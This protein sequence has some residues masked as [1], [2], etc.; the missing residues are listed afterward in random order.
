MDLSVLS[1]RL[2]QKSVLFFSFCIQERICYNFSFPF[3]PTENRGIEIKF[4]LCC[5]C[6]IACSFVKLKTGSQSLCKHTNFHIHMHTCIWEKYRF[7]YMYFQF[8]QIQFK[9]G[10]STCFLQ[11]TT[12][13][14]KVYVYLFISTHTSIVY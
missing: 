13:I 12:T 9:H 7:S 4:K 8:L 3:I 1:A 11:T 10:I 2:A 14:M 6:A 5:T